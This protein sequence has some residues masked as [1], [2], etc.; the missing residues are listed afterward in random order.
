MLQ[1]PQII[2]FLFVYESFCC[3]CVD[4]PEGCVIIREHIP[5]T[6][7]FTCLWFNEVD[8]FTSRDQL[9]FAAVRDKIMGQV[10]WSVNM[11]MD[12]ERRNFV[13]Q[14][15]HRDLLE[16]MPP[17]TLRRNRYSIPVPVSV[18][19]NLVAKSS[20]LGKKSPVKRGKGER[21]SRSRRHSKNLGN[22]D[23]MVF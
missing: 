14:A 11:F 8:R 10:D 18:R 5:I 21:R 15:Y 19:G 12:C 3:F 4:V 13:I 2:L 20:N 23:N 6:N 1:K 9:S 7:L 16:H 22:R 17:P